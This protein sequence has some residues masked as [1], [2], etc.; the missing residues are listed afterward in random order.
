MCV[1]L[2][3]PIC[4]LPCANPPA[5][6]L[7]CSLLPRCR[8]PWQSA[9][10][11]LFLSRSGALGAA[12]VPAAQ[13]PARLPAQA[14]CCLPRRPPRRRPMSPCRRSPTRAAACCA[15]AARRP[16]REDIIGEGEARCGLAK[17]PAAAPRRCPAPAR[18]GSAAAARRPPPSALPLPSAPPHH[19]PAAVGAA[20]S[21]ALRAEMITHSLGAH[22]L[23]PSAYYTLTYASLLLI[24]LLAVC[25]QSAYTVRRQRRLSLGAAD[26]APER[27]AGCR[28]AA[29]RAAVAH[30]W[31][32]SGTATALDLPPRLPL[33]PPQVVGVVGATCGTT[34]VRS[35]GG[36]GAAGCHA[37]PWQ[38]QRAG[39]RAPPA[40]AHTPLH[41]PLPHSVGL[42]FPWNAGAA[43]PRRRHPLPSLRLVPRRRG[44]AAHRHRSRGT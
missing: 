44:A 35:G 37:G 17:L 2:G 25:I 33:L 42:H 3:A 10:R 31:Q 21:C 5:C 6:P 18:R 39:G 26:M 1:R 28:H 30:V 24:Y 43:R 7:A 13:P 29:A 40:C 8:W 14:G 38:R 16:M 27:A 23:S 11:C 32:G 34:M 22:S 9:W 20:P 36:C 41:P 15:P 19:C 4:A 12:G